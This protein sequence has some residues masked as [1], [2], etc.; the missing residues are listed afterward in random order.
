MDGFKTV[1]FGFKTPVLKNFKMKFFWQLAL[2]M[3]SV[4]VASMI[5]EDTRA[6]VSHPNRHV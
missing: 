3:T 1:R 4:L 5:A 6:T 2:L